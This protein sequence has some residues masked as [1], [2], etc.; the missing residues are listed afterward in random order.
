M[1]FVIIVCE[2]DI[3]ST[4]DLHLADDEV[5]DASSKNPRSDYSTPPS[6][7]NLNS[8]CAKI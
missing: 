1:S 8:D 5:T 7:Y 3:K 2:N 4:Q 6:A